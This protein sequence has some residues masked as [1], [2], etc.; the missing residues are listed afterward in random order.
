MSINCSKNTHTWEDIQHNR[1]H[2]TWWE[3]GGAGEG[4]RSC[5]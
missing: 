5:V 3:V 4:E 2:Y 1:R